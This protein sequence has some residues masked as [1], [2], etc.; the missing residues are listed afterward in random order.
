[1]T[2]TDSA[3][4]HRFLVLHDYGMG[5]SWWWIHARSAREV[6]ETFAWVEV[7]TDPEVVA[8]FEGAE[9]EEVGIDAPLLPP[10]L[11]SLRAERDAQR[12]HEG[13]G[14]LAGRNIVYL[15][16]PWDDEDDE[17]VVYLMEIGP[18][19]RRVRQVELAED[20]T[21]LRSGPDDWPFNP[22][23]V[24]LFDPALAGQEISRREF[25]D[26]WAGAHQVGPDM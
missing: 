10:G 12:G 17:P 14:A 7:V 5:G 2:G 8:R 21:A 4:K 16:R 24:D 19:G 22:P 6:L 1:M 20:R 11:D 15:R 25:E 23:I 26:Q 18:D 13:F 9:L 3:H